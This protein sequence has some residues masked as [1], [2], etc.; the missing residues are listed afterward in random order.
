VVVS[1]WRWAPA[2]DLEFSLWLDGFGLLFALLIAGIGTL[3]VAYANAYLRPREDRGRFYLCLFLFMGAM[4]GVV[5]A[6]NVLVLYMF[7]EM[8]SI[9]S[10]LLIGFWHARGESRDGALKAMLIT[11]L[12]GL[13][14]LFGLLLM[15]A[16]AGSL[17]IRE[18]IGV[19][20]GLR[21]YKDYPLI[22]ALIL[23]AAFTKSAQAPFH[24]W[25]PGAMAAPTPVSA[26]LHS[27]TMVKA[28]IFL[29]ARM[30]TILGGT[31][32][33]FH[34][35][36]AVGIATMVLGGFLAVQQRDLKALLAY[37]TVS[38]LGFIMTMFGFG[39]DAALAAGVLHI[40]NHAV[41]KGSLF[42]AVGIIDHETGTR[43]IARLSGLGRAMPVTAAVMFLGALAMAGVPLLNG[44]V[45]KEMILEALLHPPVGAGWFPWLL[46]ALAVVG[47]VF[48]TAYCLLITLKVFLG[49]PTTDTPK[50]PHEAPWALL[51]PPL[52]LAALVVLLGVAPQLVEGTLVAGA[53]EAL[54]GSTEELHLAV[55]HGVTPALGMS[56]AA[57]AL[58]ALLYWQ[59]PRALPIF[60]WVSG[61][62]WNA[63]A[64]Y[65]RAL[66]LVEEDF[67][68]WT[69]R[70]MT[71]N[72]RDYFVYV[73]GFAIALTGFTLVRTGLPGLRA[74]VSSLTPIGWV[75]LVACLILMGGAALAAGAGLRISLAL[76]V[77][78]VGFAVAVLW[79]LWD[80]PDLALTQTIVET[81]SIIPLFLA[82]GFMPA[83]RH[84]WTAPRVR[85]WNI[86]VAVAAGVV[87]AGYT[88]L[89]QGNRLFD[90]IGHFYVE[91]SL[92]IGGGRN[93]VN[94]MLVDFR[95]FDTVFET[96]VFG[97]AGMAVFAL[98]AS[99]V[100]R[101]G[102]VR[103]RSPLMINPVIVPSVSRVLFYLV[104]V[105][106]LYLFFRG[107][108]NPGGG[109]AA[110]VMAAS[111]VVIWAL[112]YERTAAL[113]MVPVHPRNLIATG[114]STIGAV[115]LGSVLA[116]YPFLT[117]GFLHLHLPWVGQVELASAMVFD[118]GVAFTVA[119]T[120]IWLVAAMSD[121]VPL[122]QEHMTDLFRPGSEFAERG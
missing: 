69:R 84:H 117:R 101:G 40:L 27:A 10:F 82:F 96:T 6:E 110:G 114:L 118:L 23:L 61:V 71:G 106:A 78:A 116:G 46:P 13:G 67:Q 93:I 45:S 53:V 15:G 73:L 122:E 79:F 90:T 19:G 30:G 109:F 42:M 50:P 14:L 100:D 81:V 104:L 51:A 22:V 20:P 32:L 44:F 105:F 52:V 29:T 74:A 65:Q 115:G 88:L 112:A 33:W 85:P 97:L 28:G 77:A 56:G 39:T 94:V 108:H 80:A 54:R 9:S 5:M 76:G 16:W 48:T 121:G 1:T 64:V 38:Q 8:T 95:G 31:E 102:V 34:A 59:L 60:G 92:A 107:H 119:G 47:S 4:L 12:G 2:F 87:T 43:D 99:R 57:L 89:T 26:Y 113:A 63:N 11:V 103:P 7:W 17:S 83:L 24:I 72:I 36:A 62:R 21:A 41:F 18:L 70:V 49:P 3:V 111:A 35:V 68:R 66:H 120:I 58:G 98:V 25:L 75:E 86:A 55:W 37:S 91:N